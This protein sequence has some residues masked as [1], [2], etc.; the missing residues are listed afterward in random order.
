MVFLS[1]GCIKMWG[2]TDYMLIENCSVPA[3]SGKNE[4]II[5]AHPLAIEGFFA[6]SVLN[7][8]ASP[9]AIQ[10]SLHYCRKVEKST[11]LHLHEGPV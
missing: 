9:Q 2:K 7:K 4:I 1:W 6:H 10:L 5:A 8:L 11:V 3:Q